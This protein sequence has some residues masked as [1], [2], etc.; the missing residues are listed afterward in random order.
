MCTYLTET[1]SVRASAKGAAGW[2]SAERATVYFDH[3]VHLGDEHS[4]N[5][6]LLAP[7]RGPSARVGL[8]LDAESALALARA[9][10]RTL[11]TAPP[12]LV[13]DEVAAAACAEA[14][15]VPAA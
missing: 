6:D 9:I 11:A 1:L 14:G 7:S 5:V 3:P 4:L 15:A 13:P 8:E 10:L 12:G 2:F